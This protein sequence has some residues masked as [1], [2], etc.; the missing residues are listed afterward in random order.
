MSKPTLTLSCAAALLFVAASADVAR[1]ENKA[2]GLYTS[3]CKI[4]HGPAGTPSAPFAM[5]GVEDLSDPEWQDAN[6][7]DQ[8]KDVIENGVEDTL[9][10]GFG[11]ELKPAQTDSLVAF[12]RGLRRE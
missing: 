5:K 8:I 4:C 10:R 6:S 2:T 3:K 9:M 12:I 1:A 7:D 11:K